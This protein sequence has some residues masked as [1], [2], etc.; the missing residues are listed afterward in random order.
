MK[1]T[2]DSYSL[3]ENLSDDAKEIVLFIENTES[4]VNRQQD[5]L[6]NIERKMLKGTY[7]PEL[8]VKF[9][10]YYVVFCVKSNDWKITYADWKPSVSARREAARY[11]SVNGYEKVLE[12]DEER[13]I[14]KKFSSLNMSEYEVSWD[15]V[16]NS[17]YVEYLPDY[18]AQSFYLQ[19]QQLNEFLEQNQCSFGDTDCLLDILLSLGYIESISLE[20]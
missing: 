14:N 1:E 20:Y 11:F 6:K 17:V 9:W 13:G 12:K 16:N 2:Q 10:E 4:L 15:E 19:G 3:Y 5:Y 18:T 8:A 7:D